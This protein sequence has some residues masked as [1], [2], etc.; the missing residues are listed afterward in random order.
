MHPRPEGEVERRH[1]DHRGE[2]DQAAQEAGGVGMVAEVAEHRRDLGARR[3]GSEADGGEEHD[4][5]E[6]DREDELDRGLEAPG[7]LERLVRH[8]EDRHRH[9]RQDRLLEIEPLQEGGERGR[10]EQRQGEPVAGAVA[11]RQAARD[12]EQQEAEHDRGAVRDLDQ[13][14]GDRLPEE[15]GPLGQGR[16]RGARQEDRPAHHGVRG[17]GGAHEGGGTGTGAHQAAGQDQGRR[18]PRQHVIDEPVEEE[19]R[20]HAVVPPRRVAQGQEP[21]GVGRSQP[22]RDEA[23]EPDQLSD[24]EGREGR[25]RLDSRPHAVKRQV[26]DPPGHQPV[27][28]RH[29]HEPGRRTLP[30][31]DRRR[32]QA[33]AR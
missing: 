2:Q 21:V 23:H 9:E 28:D 4:R 17:D 25:A 11:T 20:Q 30:A 19:R 10:Q 14:Q 12:D 22:S 27:D 5:E 31:A 8:Q 7:A 29:R 26:E 16:R 15:G 1:G 13:R 32:D 3:E 18:G 24:E 6:T 33:L